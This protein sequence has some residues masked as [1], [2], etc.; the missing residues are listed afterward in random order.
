MRI[1]LS[2]PRLFN[3]L[4]RPGISFSH[5]E[6]KTW[7]ARPPA[8]N[9]SALAVV[10]RPGDGAL[11]L[12]VP[13]HNGAAEDV[14][15]HSYVGLFMLPSIEDALAGRHGAQQRLGV[16]VADDSWICGKSAGQVLAA[17]RA[18][19]RDLGFEPEFVRVK[20]ASAH[21]E[22]R[23][24]SLLLMAVLVFLI[25]VAIGFASR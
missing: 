7:L 25:L 13:N 24:P 16:P 12:C 23:A 8:A 20:A 14:P 3:G 17:C 18:E 15:G 2:G 19:A 6:A 4:V 11:V 1:W 9:N 5:R 21:V 22:R 10:R